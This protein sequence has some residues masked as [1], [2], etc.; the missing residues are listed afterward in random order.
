[1]RNSGLGRMGRDCKNCSASSA[2]AEPMAQRPQMVADARWL[3]PAVHV[4]VVAVTCATTGGATA[5]TSATVWRTRNASFVAA[6]G[7]TATLLRDGSVLV[8]GAAGNPRACARFS[9]GNGSSTD[10]WQATGSLSVPRYWHTAVRLA[11]GRVLVV[12]GQNT[13]DLFYSTSV[14]EAARAAEIYDPATALWYVRCCRR[15]ASARD[16]SKSRPLRH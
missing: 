7:H 13:S 5:W 16:S 15:T 3:L 12:G 8:V 11:D 4:V 1:M 14:L 6:E 2:S 9:A 10:Y